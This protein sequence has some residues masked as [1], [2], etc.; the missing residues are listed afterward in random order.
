MLLAGLRILRKTGKKSTEVKA[1]KKPGKEIIV[2]KLI[3][4]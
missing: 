4:A 1:E 3:K 2:V